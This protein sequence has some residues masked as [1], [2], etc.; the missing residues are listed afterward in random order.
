MNFK[1]GKRR[2]NNTDKYIVD[3][4]EKWCKKNKI[5]G[6]IWTD[7]KSNWKDIMKNDYNVERAYDY[8]KKSELEIRLKILEYVYKAKNLT[9]IETK[10][11][12]YFFNKLDKE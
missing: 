3:T 12:Q 8:F 11:S 9:G 4:I 10:F 2:V 6:V 1:N 7:L 5:N